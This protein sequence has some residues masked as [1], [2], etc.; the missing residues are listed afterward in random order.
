[1]GHGSGH[2]QLL[3]HKCTATADG[4]EWKAKGT[5]QVSVRPSSPAERPE[6]SH[7]LGWMLAEYIE[8]TDK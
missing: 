4:Q 5:R 7:R 2:A 1:M 6:I 3:N 8:L